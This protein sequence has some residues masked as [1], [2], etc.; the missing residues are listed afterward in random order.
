MAKTW[1]VMQRISHT[2][3][4][5]HVISL[6]ESTTD[7]DIHGWLQWAWSWQLSWMWRPVVSWKYADVPEVHTA[8]I[9]RATFAFWPYLPPCL[10]N[11]T[12]CLAVLC[13]CHFVIALLGIIGCSNVFFCITAWELACC[14]NCSQIIVRNKKRG[15]LSIPEY[16]K[17]TK[18]TFSLFLLSVSVFLQ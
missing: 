15:A 14:W 12:T 10:L 18:E 3:T 1:P 13:N 9:R 8:T 6:L 16:H 4:S 17:W 11:V 5:K 7:G 2:Y